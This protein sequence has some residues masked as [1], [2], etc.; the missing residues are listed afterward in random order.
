LIKLASM[1]RLPGFEMLL[2]ALSLNYF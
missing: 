1:I 2:M